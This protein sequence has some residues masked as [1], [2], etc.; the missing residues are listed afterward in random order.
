MIRNLFS[1]FDP[2]GGVFLNGWLAL[3]LVLISV[4][5]GLSYVSFALSS[6]SGRIIQHLKSELDI[7]LGL[8]VYSHFTSLV[9]TVFVAIFTINFVGL[10]PYVFTPTAHIILP[11]SL[12]IPF[13][14]GAYL[15]GWIL[16]SGESLAHLVPVGT[17]ALL[18]PFIVIIET[19]SAVIR[20]LTLSIRLMANI[21]AGHLLLSLTGGGINS[22]L[23]FIP[24]FLSQTILIFLELAVAAIQAYV[25]IVLITLYAKEVSV[26]NITFPYFPLSRS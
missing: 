7:P 10:I 20:P 26:T 13:W 24:L 12:A 16:K 1:I 25:F 23:S 4:P 9:L 8:G 17:P 6:A 19:I 21:V 3:V 18:I 5:F 2:S 14:G 15:F 11:L 22:T